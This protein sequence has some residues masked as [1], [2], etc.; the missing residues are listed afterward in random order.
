MRWAF[1]FI[2]DNMILGRVNK[3]YEISGSDRKGWRKYAHHFH[4]LV[5]TLGLLAFAATSSHAGTPISLYRTFAG[6]LNYVT[7]GGTLRTASNTAY[8][9]S[10]CAVTNGPVSAALS[11]IPAGATIR[12]A[13]LYWAGSGSTPDNT[14]TFNGNSVTADRT[15][16]ESFFNNPTTYYFFS[17]FKD[18]TAYITGNGTYSFSNLTVDTSTTYCGVQVVLSGWAL[19]VVYQNATEPLRV[20]NVYDGFQYFRGG[21]LSLTPSNFR[22]PATGIDGKHTHITW[23]GDPDTGTSYTLNGYDENFNFN[24]ANLTDTLNPSN[25]QFNS[26]INTLNSSTSYGV[27]IDTYDISSRLTAGAT[28]ATSV[29]SSGNDLVLLSSEV[30]SVTNTLVADLNLTKT[31]SGSFP[32]GGIGTF[33]LNVH[34]NG[35]SAATGT[36]GSPITVTDIIPAGFTYLSSS[37]TGWTI[38]TSSLPTVR[39]T[40]TGTVASGGNLPTITL[41]V[42]VPAAVGTNITNTAN[43]AG[44]DFDNIMSNNSSSDNVTVVLLPPSLTVVKSA[45][46]SPAVN[47]GQVV[48]YSV[49]VTNSGAGGAVSVVAQDQLSPY[50]SWGINSYGTGVPFQVIDAAS[51]NQSGLTLG[52]PVYSNNNGTTWTYAPV[53]GGGGAPAGYDSNVTNWR[54]PMPGTMNTNG[55][56]FTINY[57]V[58]VK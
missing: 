8:T 40:Y 47:P 27:D 56:N 11:G 54:I 21:A 58:R 29:Y 35:P 18:V 42:R 28:S 52:T 24:G 20:I 30:L 41:Q 2:G 1:F 49:L 7:T 16:T 14:V 36:A 50:V 51:P 12:A 9:N 25:N 39:W 19:V 10:A 23:E 55:A 22:I 4:S 6:N 44:P 26:T 5:I 57:Q 15:F 3:G 31:H 37:G 17:G 34:N 13:Y 43:V 33:Q 46:P 38:D 53:S 32:S 48:T 45:S